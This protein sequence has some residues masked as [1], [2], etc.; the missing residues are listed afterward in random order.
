MIKFFDLVA[1]LSDLGSV[2]WSII[3]LFDDVDDALHA[4]EMPQGTH[5]NREETNINY[6][7]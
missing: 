5:I 4:W 2:P 6:T 7:L 3:E 1:F